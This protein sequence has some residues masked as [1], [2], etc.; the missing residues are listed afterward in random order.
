MG[1]MRAIKRRLFC[2]YICLNML[3]AALLFFPWILPRETISGFVGRQWLH[4]KEDSLHEFWFMI[5]CALINLLYFWEP[6]H[7]V[8]V[9][10]SEHEA[11]KVLYPEGR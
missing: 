3:T 7:C 11:R 2:V 4:S 1:L 6:N 9:Y 8:E 5:L 10:R